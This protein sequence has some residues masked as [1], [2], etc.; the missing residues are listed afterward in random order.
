MRITPSRGQI[1]YLDSIGVTDRRK[2]LAAAK[3]LATAK[4]AAV[5][6][7]T[8]VDAQAASGLSLPEWLVGLSIGAVTAAVLIFVVLV[9]VLL[10]AA[11]A[12]AGEEAEPTSLPPAKA[13]AEDD[14]KA[15]TAPS[16]AGSAA[17]VAHG[18]V[19]MAPPAGSH[20]MRKKAEDG[21]A[22][23]VKAQ[24]EPFAAAGPPRVS[25]ATTNDNMEVEPSGGEHGAETDE[26]ENA[27]LPD[28]SA[29]APL[30]V[31]DFK[32]LR[33]RVERLE[34]EIM[35]RRGSV[36]AAPG[37]KGE[38]WALDRELYG[39]SA[40]VIVALVA[41]VGCWCAIRIMR[42]RRRGERSRAPNSDV[43]RSFVIQSGSR[44]PAGA[45]RCVDLCKNDHGGS[46][47]KTGWNH[48]ADDADIR[49]QFLTVTTGVVDAPWSIGGRSITGQVRSKNEDYLI[50]AG[51]SDY[52]V[53]VLADGCGGVPHG[54]SASQLAADAAGAELVWHL[55]RSPTCVNRAIETAFNAAAKR[56]EAE[57]KQRG[58]QEAH[59]GLRTTLV[60][61]VAAKRRF[62]CCFIGDGGCEILHAD[63][64]RTVLLVPQ[65]GDPAASNVLAASLGPQVQGKPCFGEADRKPG[66]LLLAG[67][68]GVFD[69]VGHDFPRNLLRLA[70]MKSGDLNAAVESALDDLAVAQ[71][72]NGYICDD[73]MTL[74]VVGDGKPPTLARGFWKSS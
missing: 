27:R 45:H 24:P 50:A 5:A 57:G 11:A 68:D 55:T 2:P 53:V 22:A 64:S 34:A 47:S 70:I 30:D 3:P 20:D 32:A 6:K 39:A 61:L 63:G 16:D 15:S 21:A 26:T 8:P 41:M 10:M 60:I 7:P 73:N 29:P 17:N 67:T 49:C 33:A 52:Q 12:R 46:A 48:V 25:K 19:T 59:D 62:Y 38:P 42:P 31:V 74:A 4:P 14:K 58:I 23:N 69:R 51:I 18:G 56:L 37:R 13:S 72:G 9:V 40:R 28:M 36:H 71:D 54:A 1:D 66:D 35:R 43:E 44:R 65:R